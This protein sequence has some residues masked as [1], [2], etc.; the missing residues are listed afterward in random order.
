MAIL[1]LP[2]SKQ[3]FGAIF[4]TEMTALMSLGIEKVLHV[5]TKRNISASHAYDHFYVHHG[6]DRIHIV[7]RVDDR[8]L[9]YPVSSSSEVV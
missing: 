1:S 4:H 2:T 5:L 7:T 6:I 3:V 8:S 9:G